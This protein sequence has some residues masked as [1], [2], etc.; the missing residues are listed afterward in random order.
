MNNYEETYKKLRETY[1][2]AEIA[3][4]FMIPETVTDQEAQI[5]AEA[6]RKMRFEMLSKRTDEQRMLS[7]VTRLRIKINEYLKEGIFLESQSFGKILDEYIRILNRSKKAFAEEID[8][9]YTKLSRI[10]NGKEAP[11]IS[12][13]YRLEQHTSEL[14]PA[15]CWWKLLVKQQE[16]AIQADKEQRKIEQKRVKNQLRLGM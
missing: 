7:E 14:I 4:G 2:D 11:S 12:L 16:Q 15:I 10:I 9:H 1:S 3:E 6:F 5:D 13:I 8:L